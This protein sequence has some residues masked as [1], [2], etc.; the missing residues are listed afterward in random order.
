MGRLAIVVPVRSLA[1]GKTRLDPDASP[2]MRQALT[3]RM[4]RHVLQAAIT[5]GGSCDVL[6]VSP[7]PA[8]LEI[9]R[10]FDGIVT[11]V[12][13]QSERPGL[14]PA[15]DLGRET[16][17][18]VGADRML[19]LFADL[20]LLRAEDVQAILAEESP[21]V[22]APDRAGRGTNA[23]LTHLDGNAASFRFAFGAGSAAAHRTEAARLGLD[24]A[25]VR[26]RGTTF[27]LDTPDNLCELLAEE[28][29]GA[30]GLSRESLEC[31]R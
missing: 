18:A 28:S 23:L 26:T 13:Q 30:W 14:N 8:A 7:D 9:A 4:L 24:V 15:I 10:E 21:V 27:D 2:E 12:L 25:T 16:A 19:V 3:V 29:P 17:V 5:G 1:G 22:L 11:Q 6:L 20:P 31:L